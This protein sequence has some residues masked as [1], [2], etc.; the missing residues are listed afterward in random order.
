MI[1]LHMRQFDGITF[2]MS[3]DASNPAFRRM[4]RNAYTGKVTPRGWAREKTVRCVRASDVAA[5]MGEAGWLVRERHMETV[6]WGEDGEEH[7]IIYEEAKT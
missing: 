3:V 1:D 4:K 6:S 7:Y 5:A 2:G